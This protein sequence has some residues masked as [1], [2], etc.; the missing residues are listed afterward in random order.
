VSD[1]PPLPAEGEESASSA[2]VLAATSA[3][4]DVVV[5]AAKREQ[6]LGNVASAV[7]VVSADRIRRFGYRTVGE[8]VAGV[9][10]TYLE[11]SRLV[12][13]LGIRGL[14]IPGD[15]NTRIL[16][17]VDGATVNEAWGAFAGLGFDTFVSIDD[18][19]R[20]EVIRGPVSSVYGANAFFGIINI[21]TRG[22]SETPKAWGRVGVNSINGTIAAAGFAAGD[23]S[24]QVRGSVQASD[25]F[26]ETLYLSDVGDSLKSDGGHAL[27]VSLVGSY[28][29]AFAQLRAY[30]FRRDVPFAP[31]NGDATSGDPYNE[32]DTQLLAEGGY[33]HEM[34]KR[35]T[36]AVRGYANVYQFSDN[37]IQIAAPD[38]QDFGDAATLGGEVRARYEIMPQTLGLTAGAE[39]N[40]NN[41]E[42]HSFMLGD[43]GVTIPKDFDIEGAYAE[44]DGQ[45][46]NYV[47]F[48][49]GGRFDRNS[50]VDKNVSP[51]AALFLAQPDT[52]GLKLLYAQGF[53]NPSA[54]EA[55]FFDNASFGQPG[56]LSAETIQ[57]LEA[58]LWAKPVPGLSTRLSAFYWDATKVLEAVTD[59]DTQLQV[60]QNVGEL[61]TRG[62]EAEL[63]Y[64][65]S[66]GWYGFGG[67][68]YSDVGGTTGD[69]PTVVYG[70]V[71][72]A[73][74][75]TAAGGVSTPKLFGYAHLSTELIAIGERPTRTNI[76]TSEVEA[77]SPAW[78]DWN[79]TVYIP[80][81]RGFDITAGVRNIIGKR[82]LVPTSGDYDRTNDDPGTTIPRV[83]GE[84]REVYVKVGYSY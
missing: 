19:A 44:L 10:G 46:G 3:S 25:R 48:V 53:R 2:T 51:R 29:G 12:G 58:V 13:S 73:P 36:L 17:L 5:G 68:A 35:L 7:T 18:V 75:W 11:D 41:T 6:S 24:K 52:I 55:F 76:N 61:V 47:G 26:G 42:S 81:V 21:V 64:R 39:A 37:I 1:L 71:P 23:L 27:A 9:A 4:E 28:A 20:I 57:S 78:F 8:A 31:Y 43:Q 40:Y 77:T 65:N 38:F 60:F 15:Y 69:D 80:N 63:S 50:A 32:Y 59:M 74:Q 16:V 14:N 45:L 79:A 49:G 70:S 33:T 84:G 34:S 72:D 54:Y 67:A 66:S 30:R 62:V 56:R 83:P 22:A 82:N